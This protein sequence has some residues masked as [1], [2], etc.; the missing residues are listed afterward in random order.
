MDTF[1]LITPEQIEEVKNRLIAAYNPTQIYLFGSYAWGTPHV[2][3]DLD[4]MVVI[5]KFEPVVTEDGDVHRPSF[6]GRMALWG[7]SIPKDLIVLTAD[8]FAEKS[9]VEGKL[10]YAVKHYGK[11]LYARS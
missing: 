9:A 3:S 5:D 11:L 1:K 2:D 8:Q 4:L 10:A 6:A 7:L